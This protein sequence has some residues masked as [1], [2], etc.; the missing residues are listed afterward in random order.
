MDKALSVRPKRMKFLE[1]NIEWKL[2]HLVWQWFLGDDTESTDI[3]RTEKSGLHKKIL[4]HTSKDPTHR[5]THRTGECLQ[6]TYLIRG[7]Y[8][9]Y[10][11]NSCN[12]TRNQRSQLKTGQRIWKHISPK[13]YTNGQQAHGKALSII[14]AAVAV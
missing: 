2:W 12:S 7:W 3:K 9:A 1:A 8:P 6:S 4:S 10:R 5:T 14:M 13:R 11:Q